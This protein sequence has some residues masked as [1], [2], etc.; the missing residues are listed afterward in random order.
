[1]KDNQQDY[2]FDET[3]KE[4]WKGMPDFSIIPVI[5]FRTIKISFRKKEDIEEF[6]KLIGQKIHPNFENYWHPKLY[7]LGI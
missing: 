6:E 1:M 3:W 4:H 7:I 5:P 2:L